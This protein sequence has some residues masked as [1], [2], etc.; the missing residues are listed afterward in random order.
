[1]CRWTS[2]MVFPPLNS[3]QHWG[4][5]MADPIK[6]S[7]WISASAILPATRRFLMKA[8]AKAVDKKKLRP[9]E[10]IRRLVP[11]IFENTLRSG[12]P[13]LN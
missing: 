10:L 11:L 4:P 1:M 8:P 3:Y 5:A 12:P 13:R 9:F 2:E 6:V 7:E